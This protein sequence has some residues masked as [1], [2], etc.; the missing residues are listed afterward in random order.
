MTAKHNTDDLGVTVLGGHSATSSHLPLLF[1]LYT[2]L[3]ASDCVAHILL[4]GIQGKEEQKRK[5][6]LSL[7]KA[8][9][10]AFK[11][12]ASRP[13]REAAKSLD[14]IAPKNDARVYSPLLSLTITAMS[15][16]LSPCCPSFWPLLSSGHF[17]SCQCC[18]KAFNA[19]SL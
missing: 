15:L 12:F 16:P 9:E 11:A 7:S 6:D 3:S 5:Q 1:C 2:Y 10:A 13:R 14:S 19:Q 18:L 17:C 4:L 8:R